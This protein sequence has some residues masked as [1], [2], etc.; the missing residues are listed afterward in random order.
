[1]PSVLTEARRIVPELTDAVKALDSLA[2]SRQYSEVFADLIDW[3]VFEHTMPLSDKN[4]LN[5]KY[6]SEEQNLFKEALKNIQSEVRKRVNIWTA[7]GNPKN[8]Q[9]H[10]WYDPLGKLYETIT[11]KYK[12]SALGQYF[13]PQPVVDMM[14]QMTNPGRSEKVETILDP[15]CG[16]GR[17][18][19][20][21]ATYARSKGTPTYVCMNDL[22]GICTKMTAVNMAMNGVVGE[23]TCMNGLDIEGNSY[24]FGY[25]VEPLLAS[26]PQQMWEYYRM[27]ILMKTGQDVKK[28][29]VLKPIEY[30][31]TLIEK[32]NQKILT[33]LKERQKIADEEKRKAAMEELQNQ[34]KARMA[35]TLFEGENTIINDIKLP[36]EI[37]KAKKSQVNKQAPKPK[38]SQQGSLF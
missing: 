6:D 28:Q 8:Y 36:S 4:P 35:G 16:S 26:L 19:L 33:E 29:Y 15:A 12:S 3:L 32:S 1:M 18:G 9:P 2:Y 5:K 13:T 31:N 20:S 21:A 30:K 11:S 37:K 10:G 25:R 24:R 22:D 7:A 17:M 34:I 14:V 27:L 38:D 23:A